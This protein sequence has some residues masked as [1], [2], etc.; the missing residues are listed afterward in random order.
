M[1]QFISFLRQGKGADGNMVNELERFAKGVLAQ[2]AR[3]RRLSGLSMMKSEAEVTAKA[4]RLLADQFFQQRYV[5]GY[6]LA[7]LSALALNP[8]AIGMSMGKQGSKFKDGLAA[9]MQGD[10]PEAERQLFGGTAEGGHDGFFLQLAGDTGL[11][12]AHMFRRLYLEVKQTAE[13]RL[14]DAKRMCR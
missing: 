11:K 3:E 1:R 8:G 9:L 10:I 4:K 5:R 2:E 14:E 12:D 13:R 7:A 6:L